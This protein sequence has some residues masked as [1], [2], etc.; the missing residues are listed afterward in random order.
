VNGTVSD[1]GTIAPGTD[2]AMGTLTLNS[3]P[4]LNGTVLMK[5]DR[6]GGAPLNDQIYQPSSAVTYGGTLTVMN[7]GADLQAGDVFQLFN[8][9]GYGGSLDVTNL[10][11]LD[12][13]LA[14]SNSL[15]ANGSIAVVVS[16]VSLVPTNIV[17]NVSG[18]N[19][20]LSWPADH[21]GWRLQVQTN[22]LA[23]SNWV[24][25]PGASLTNF[26]ALPVDPTVGSMYYRLIYP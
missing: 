4:A 9:T 14:W 2:S 11:P 12:S 6:N 22:S 19:L 7:V 3:S 23:D 1:N 5:I 18:T 21:T 17:W 15:A 13:G 8:A 25:V 10:P 16:T 20:A 24:D 26:E